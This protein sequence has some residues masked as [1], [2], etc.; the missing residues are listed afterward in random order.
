V[1]GSHSREIADIVEREWRTAHPRSEVITRQIGLDPVPATAWSTA[2]NATYVP[3]DERSPAQCEAVS[4]AGQA[5]I[6]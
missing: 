2:V 4:L 3:T 5:P 1:E 6:S